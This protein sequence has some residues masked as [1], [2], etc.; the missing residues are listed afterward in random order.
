MVEPALKMNGSGVEVTYADGTG[1][2]KFKGS[3]IV[4]LT[5]REEMVGG[6]NYDSVLAAEL[7]QIVGSL[8][9]LTPYVLELGNKVEE[10]SSGKI[11]VYED[12]KKVK[13]FANIAIFFSL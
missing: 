7:K 5:L 11:H 9:K 2:M 10:D 13:I 1:N 4:K 12:G 8:D 6:V 3:A